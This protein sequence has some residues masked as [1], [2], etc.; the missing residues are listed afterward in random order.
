MA[1]VLAAVR[2]T[3]GDCLVQCRKQLEYVHGPVH[4]L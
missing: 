3:E 2:V 4:L 1:G